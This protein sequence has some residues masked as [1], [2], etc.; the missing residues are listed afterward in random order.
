[1][2]PVGMLDIF[3][4]RFDGNGNFLWAK[5]VGG[6]GWEAGNSITV[7][8]KGNNYLTGWFSGAVDFD[9]GPGIHK[10]TSFDAQD[11]FVSAMDANGNFLWARQLGGPGPRPIT[12]SYPTSGNAISLDIFGNVYT[13]GSF[14]Y[15][16]DFDPEAGIFNLSSFGDIDIFVHKM[17]RCSQ[18]APVTVLASACGTYT[19]NGQI[20]D[21]TGVYTQTLNNAGGCDSLVTL[22]LTI[23]S[24][25]LT[26]INK[27]ICQGENFEGYTT[28]GTYVDTLVAQNGC[29]SIIILNLTVV[30]SPTPDLG[31]DKNLCDGDSLV[32]LPGRFNSYLWQD[33]SIQSTLT[34]KQ[35]GLYSV[36]V[37]DNCG[38][39]RDEIL[40]K[41]TEC[42]FLFPSAFTPNNDGKNDLF[43]VLG[44]DELA[45]FNLAVYDRWGQKV[46]STNDYKKGWDGY[47][48][49]RLLGTGVYAWYCTFRKSN[50]NTTLK[51][52]VLLIR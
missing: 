10:I 38:T 51:G 17:S 15:T 49:G 40:V 42:S 9:P 48:K 32:L 23:T 46:F 29:D 35:P 33:G 6:P 41:E 36:T 4:S 14:N 11:I 47:F 28:T 24:K 20:Y 2:A 44:K 39:G 22:Q 18:S 52:T 13:T 8:T 7:D 3:V 5:Q 25:S 16:V 31:A 30:T 1:M 27:T 21:A 19:F 34:V 43:K 26:E 12:N 45:E 50:K 37:T